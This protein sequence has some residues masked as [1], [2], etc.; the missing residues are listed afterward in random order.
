M[1][2]PHIKEYLKKQYNQMAIRQKMI[3]SLILF[4]IIPII[5]L[6]ILFSVRMFRL[7][8]RN[9][10]EMQINQLLRSAN[11]IDT[12][13]QNVIR[14]QLS[15]RETIRSMLYCLATLQ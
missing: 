2:Q 7:S 8:E 1:R 9:Q 4:V 3:M 12:M 13:N 15:Y 10:Y 5:V 14:R 6:G 11:D